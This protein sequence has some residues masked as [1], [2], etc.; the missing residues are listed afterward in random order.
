[1]LG[2]LDQADQHRVP[3][4]LIVR[5]II[6]KADMIAWFGVIIESTGMGVNFG[7]EH[8]G[9]IHKPA[10]ERHQSRRAIEGEDSGCLALQGIE[11]D[12]AS[13][14]VSGNIVP[15]H[16]ECQQIHLAEQLI[17]QWLSEET[18]QQ[19]KL[20]LLEIATACFYEI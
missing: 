15:I 14:F 9:G 16:A 1:M 18:I 20:I 2:S 5:R 12:T 7:T 17:D 8:K 6:M 3:L 13:L 4:P 10:Q 19:D 11:T